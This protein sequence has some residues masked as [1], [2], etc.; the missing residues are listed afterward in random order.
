MFE[1]FLQ[2]PAI[3]VATVC[4]SKEKCS[5]KALPGTGF[6]CC[7]CERNGPAKGSCQPPVLI[8]QFITD[9]DCWLS[10]RLPLLLYTGGRVIFVHFGV[11][12]LGPALDAKVV[13]PALTCGKEVTL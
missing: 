12:C 5:S 8:L 9:A 3:T 1:S 11:W 7:Q 13:L 2:I 4:V 10:H 6:S